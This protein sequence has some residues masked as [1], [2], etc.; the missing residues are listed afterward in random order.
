MA[1]TPFMTSFGL[2]LI[3]LAVRV[4]V[5]YLLFV[6]GLLAPELATSGRTVAGVSRD[7]SILL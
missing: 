6:A 3:S 7:S 1:W 2:E 4:S 5:A